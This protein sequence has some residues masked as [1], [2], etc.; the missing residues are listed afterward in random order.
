MANTSLILDAITNQKCVITTIRPNAS[1][2]NPPAV[3]IQYIET[4]GTAR[5]EHRILQKLTGYEIK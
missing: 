5:E 3:A 1:T 2:N 4:K